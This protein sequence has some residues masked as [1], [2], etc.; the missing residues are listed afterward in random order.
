MLS[1]FLLEYKSQYMMFNCI[2]LSNKN[3]LLPFTYYVSCI[4]FCIKYMLWLTSKNIQKLIFNYFEDIQTELQKK[5]V[6]PTITT[7]NGEAFYNN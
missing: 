1:A 2:S 5:I 6:K 7:I 4:S 3:Y